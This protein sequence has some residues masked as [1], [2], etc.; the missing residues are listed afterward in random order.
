MT[1]TQT[2]DRSRTEEARDRATDVASGAQEKAGQVAEQAKDQAANV[3][4]AAG[5]KASELVGTARQELRDRAQSE[6]SNAGDR[7]KS[8]AEELRAM[9]KTSEEQGGM[10]ASLVSQLADK[11]DTGAQRLS[12]GDLDAVVEDVKRFARN[13]PGAFLLGAAGAGFLVGRILRSADLQEVKQAVT[14]TS[15]P[16]DQQSLSSSPSTSTVA[17]L[18]AADPGSTPATL[19]TPASGATPDLGSPS[20]PT[21]AF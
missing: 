16:E 18:P 7:L 14:P 9:G 2:Q 3:A 1:D 17:P 11:V 21:G 10:T 19:G 6:A 13:R 20:T 4:S 12:D 5:E 15:G 8:I